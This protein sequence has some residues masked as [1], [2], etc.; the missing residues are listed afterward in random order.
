MGAIT[1]PNTFVNGTP[2]DATEVNDNFTAITDV[3]NGSIDGDNISTVP[4]AQVVFGDAGHTHE[5][6]TTGA[7]IPVGAA[8]LAADNGAQGTLLVKTGTVDA[9]ATDIGA[10]VFGTRFNILLGIFVTYTSIGWGQATY[11][12]GGSFVAPAEGYYLRNVTNLGFEIYN[13][14][15]TAK[16]C[17][18]RAWGI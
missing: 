3:V 9:P 16:T 4:E 2:A 14:S 5:G 13:V 12:E 11:A 6:G 7:N 1:I 8:A 17:A 10:V 15:G 18:W